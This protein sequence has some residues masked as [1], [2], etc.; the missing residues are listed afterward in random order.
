MPDTPLPRTTRV[1]LTEVA[2]H[3]GVSVGAV[4]Q[5]LNDHPGA[6]ISQDARARIAAAVEELG[7][8]PNM[9]A[10]SLRTSRTGTLGFVSDNVTIT[11][12]ATGILRGA[13]SAAK[14]RGTFLL[15]AETGGDEREEREAVASL[16][17]RGVDGF[18]FAAQKSRYSHLSTLTRGV[19][20]VSVNLSDPD[21]GASILPDELEGGRTAVRA[22]AEAGHTRIALIGYDFRGPADAG[23]A[24]TARRRL[25]GVAD[26]LAARGLELVAQAACSDWQP[27]EGY[28]AAR[29]VLDAAPTALLCLNDRLAF[30]AYQAVAER[31]LLIPRDVSVVSFDD[32]ELAGAVR[33]GITTVA[34]PHE[35]MGAEAIRLLLDGPG[36]EAVLLPMHLH[37]RDSIAPPAALV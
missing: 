26:E 36:A 34:I 9:V 15:I 31:G 20:S 4:S 28:R 37:E 13:L 5:V 30:G 33:P 17:D 8:R 23:V 18:V 25:E 16:L 3:A 14:A 22:L 27:D 21:H 7:Y 24:L 6:R 29:E 19:P 1:T 35:A 12:Y 2:R 11:R 32:D 10:R